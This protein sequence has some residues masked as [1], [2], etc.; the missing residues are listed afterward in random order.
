MSPALVLVHGGRHDA[1]CWAPTVE[2]LR[3]RRPDVP[4]L[5][6]DLPGRGASCVPL[7]EVCLQMCVDAVVDSVRAAGHERIVL[8]GHSMAGLVVPPAAAVLGAGVVERIVLLAA[9]VPR[10]GESV[11]DGLAPPLRAAA[12]WSTRPSVRDRSTVMAP[13]LARA[14][15]CNGMTPAQK[16]LVV[17]GLVP[18]ASWLVRE[19]VTVGP[20]PDVPVTWVLTLRDRAVRPRVQRRTIATLATLDQVVKIDACHDVMISH[21]DHLAD[22]LLAQSG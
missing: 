11:L 19:R 2:A 16:R 5:A 9:N 15:F 7:P 20:P 8:V 14:V 22:V 1:R 18:E 21:P 13:A 17:D 12:W 10:V 3:A 4:V 6:G